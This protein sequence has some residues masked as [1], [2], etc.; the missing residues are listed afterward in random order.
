MHGWVVTI[1]VTTEA[2]LLLTSI[3]VGRH[4]GRHTSLINHHQVNSISP[5]GAFLSC[6][7]TTTPP[8][9]TRDQSDLQYCG[10]PVCT[11][12]DVYDCIGVGIIAPPV[13]S[14][15]RLASK[16]PNLELKVLVCH[17]LNIKPN[18]RDCCHHLEHG[19]F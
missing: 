11:I 6:L 17:R 16:I 19:K 10:A 9:H 5:Y 8:I 4:H 14:D 15:A 13:R 2:L 12:D 1:L 18:C 7:N 3:V